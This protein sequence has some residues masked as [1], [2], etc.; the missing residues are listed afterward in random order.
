LPVDFSVN[1]SY[2]LFLLT[3][4]LCSQPIGTSLISWS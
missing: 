2:A 1:V 4:L 3:S